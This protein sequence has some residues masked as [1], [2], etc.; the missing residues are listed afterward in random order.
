MLVLLSAICRCRI[1]SALLCT[2]AI[3]NLKPLS[4]FLLMIARDLA[5]VCSGQNV[6]YWAQKDLE[7]PELILI[8]FSIL[9]Y[10]EVSYNQS[11]P[12]PL[13]PTLILLSFWSN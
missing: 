6:S 12:L 3:L 10:Q 1:A 7:T 2:D 5:T 9:Q 11:L 4:T 8:L 13:P